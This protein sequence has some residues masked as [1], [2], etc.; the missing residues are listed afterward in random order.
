MM[1]MVK[2]LTMLSLMDEINV[3]GAGD[4]GALYYDHVTYSADNDDATDDK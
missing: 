1:K 4:D 2:M 3:Y